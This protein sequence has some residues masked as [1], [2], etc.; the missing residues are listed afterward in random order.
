MKVKKAIIPAAG[1]GTRLLPASKAIPKEML[2]IVDKPGIQYII[3]E[4]VSSGLTE[5]VLVTGQGKSC[6]EDH[7]D[8]NQELEKVLEKSGKQDILAGIQEISRMVTLTSVRQKIQLGT[9]DA[10]LCAAQ[11]AEGE[12]VAILYPDDLIDAEIP[13]TRQ[14]MDVSA[15]YDGGGVIAIREVPDQD[16]HL[17]GIIEGEPIDDKLFLIKNIVEKPPQG[18]APSNLAIIG[19]YVLPESIFPILRE[20][21]PSADGEIQLAAG[22]SELSRR[23]KLYGYQFS[24]T[25]YDVG[26]KLGLVQATIGYALKRPDLSP[27][28][29]QWLGKVIQDEA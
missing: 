21:K 7:F 28:L 14:M 8:I 19:R 24:G 15:R 9:G 26:D 10:V 20:L 1:W 16:T 22:L 25:R 5:I 13:V 18:T 27:R 23:Q 12:P 3:E 17:Y 4:V 29:R 6:I 2:P 11:I